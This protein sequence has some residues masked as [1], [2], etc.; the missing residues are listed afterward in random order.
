MVAA[1]DA[2]ELKATE[3]PLCG[4]LH[5]SRDTALARGVRKALCPVSGGSSRVALRNRHLKR[6]KGMVGGSSHLQQED[7]A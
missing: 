1:S 4:F 7:E 5:L 3:V 2:L 6:A